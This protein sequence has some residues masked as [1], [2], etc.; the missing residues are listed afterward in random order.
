MGHDQ[1]GICHELLGFHGHFMGFNQPTWY[2]MLALKI[3]RNSPKSTASSCVWNSPISF[4]HSHIYIYRGFKKSRY[5]QIII[6]VLSPDMDGENP[7]SI[8]FWSWFAIHRAI[9]LGANK[10][11]NVTTLG[12][13]QIYLYSLWFVTKVSQQLTVAAM[14]F[15]QQ[16]IV[17]E[18]NHVFGRHLP[19][20]NLT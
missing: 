10:K 14:V 12:L 6:Q 1:H 9:L 11:S 16:L 17:R 13:W 19:S 20:G 18:Q 5:P 7:I 4:W 15:T 8:H 3:H 2:H